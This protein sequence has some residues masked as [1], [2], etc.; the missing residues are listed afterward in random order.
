MLR[1][2]QCVEEGNEKE[3]FNTHTHCH[4][5]DDSVESQWWSDVAFLWGNLWICLRSIA[6]LLRLLVLSSSPSS[7]SSSSSP[8]PLKISS[9]RSR[10]SLP[11][12][13]SLMRISNELNVSQC[14]F[15]FDS[16]DSDINV[17]IIF[18]MKIIIVYHHWINVEGA[19]KDDDTYTP[20]DS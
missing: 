1:G 7:S 9:W 11:R 18:S 10:C 13:H 15:S 16:I 8:F 3:A 4:K 2:G 19:T 14:C 12:C 20:W 5:K 6:Q 17:E